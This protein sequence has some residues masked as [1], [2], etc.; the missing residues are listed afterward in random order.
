M[1]FILKTVNQRLKKHLKGHAFQADLSMP[2]TIDLLK[3]L[4]LTK[5]LLKIRECAAA[6]ASRKGI[7]LCFLKM[8]IQ[9]V[10]ENQLHG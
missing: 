6:E 5:K 8:A 9:F 7:C 2:K 10:R 3:L 1:N 4:H